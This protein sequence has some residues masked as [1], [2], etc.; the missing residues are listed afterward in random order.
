MVEQWNKLTIAD[1]DPEFLDKYN[2][3]ISKVSIQNG[4]DNNNTDEK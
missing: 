3:L 4:E 1:K 2:C